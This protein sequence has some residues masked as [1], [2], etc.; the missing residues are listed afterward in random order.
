[1][2]QRLGSA[3]GLY[4]GFI[5]RTGAAPEFHPCGGMSKG[6]WG[7]GN[8]STIGHIMR[9]RSCLG[10]QP[11]GQGQGTGGSCPLPPCWRRP[12]NRNFV[13]AQIGLHHRG[14]RHLR[15]SPATRQELCARCLPA[16]QLKHQRDC[17][18]L[19]PII[20]DRSSSMCSPWA[21][22]VE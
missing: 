15:N 22:V 17:V 4:N 2:L 10:G 14:R 1:M 19:V 12:C 21:A 8:I 3:T 9:N 5:N 7:Q 20:S 13:A 6:T 18:G 11:G 16:H